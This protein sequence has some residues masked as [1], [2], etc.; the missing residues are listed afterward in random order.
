MGAMDKAILEGAGV[1]S[2]D[3]VVAEYYSDIATRTSGRQT[4]R[5]CRPDWHGALSGSLQM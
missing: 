2:L 1:K 3:G 5:H 4:G